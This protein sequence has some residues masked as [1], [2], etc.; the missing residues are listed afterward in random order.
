MAPPYSE[1]PVVTLQPDAAG[2]NAASAAVGM[3]RRWEG[4]V[5]RRS[6]AIGAATKIVM[7]NGRKEHQHGL[8][9][10]VETFLSA[11]WVDPHRF[12]FD[13]C[14]VFKLFC[15]KLAPRI[16]R[17][18]EKLSRISALFLEEKPTKNGSAMVGSMHNH[19]ESSGFSLCRT[20]GSTFVHRGELAKITA[21]R[22]SFW[23]TCSREELKAP[24][25]AM[26]LSSV[27]V[28][29]VGP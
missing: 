8:I 6:W 7:E 29:T 18:W 21:N 11:Q 4:S 22:W 25:S 5:A 15:W 19:R 16:N 2:Y 13:F 3:A 14:N 20:E 1:V 17:N 28:K 26:Q 10:W 12:F 9:S 23:G 27:P 24:S